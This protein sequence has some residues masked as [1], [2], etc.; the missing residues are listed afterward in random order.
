M[1]TDFQQEQYIPLPPRFAARVRSGSTIVGLSLL[2]GTLLLFGTSAL[3]NDLR[4]D[5]ALP[6]SILGKVAMIVPPA[7]VL[8]IA[9]LVL[10]CR[11]CLSGGYLVVARARAVQLAL[12][13]WFLVGG[14][15]VFVTMM[16]PIL[17]SVWHDGSRAPDIGAIADLVMVFI[18]VITGVFYVQPSERTLRKFSDH[19]VY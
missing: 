11:R 15:F 8:V 6:D 14:V 7:V 3:M 18:G 2:G 13:L 9:A 10:L 17:F 12:L 1:Q 16:V 19:P 4:H 5:H